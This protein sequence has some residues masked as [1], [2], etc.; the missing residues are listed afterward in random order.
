MHLGIRRKPTLYNVYVRIHWH[1]QNLAQKKV[2]WYKHRQLRCVRQ[3]EQWI[4][5]YGLSK[6]F[7]ILM[8]SVKVR[9]V[10]KSASK[11]FKVFSSKCIFKKGSSKKFFKKGSSKK[12]LQK[13]FFKNGSS[14][15][16]LQK[17]FLKKSSSKKV[18]QKR[19][20]KKGSSKKVLQKWFFKT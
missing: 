7:A 14:K 15:K 1:C 2:I 3:R 19:F 5:F 6:N 11:S 13:R 4:I 9:S 17:R 20:F 12:V 10:T 18:L 8:D 16:V